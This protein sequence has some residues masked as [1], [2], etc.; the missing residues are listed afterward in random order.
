LKDHYG[1]M[2][3]FSTAEAP[4]GI[5]DAILSPAT[6][7]MQA[8]L[9]KQCMRE[10]VV[11]MLKRPF[12]INPVTRMWLS[13]DGNSFLRHSLSEYLKVVEIGIA[14]V[15]GSVQDERTFSTVSFLKNKVCNR[16]TTHGIVSEE[17][18]LQPPYH[19]LGSSGWHDNQELL[20][21]QFVPL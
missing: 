10:N 12:T 9:F 6:L 18:S 21:H 5:L 14:I 8:S 1:K 7:N 13:I 17:Q 11:C 4:E 15:L 20:R 16:L 19:P 3:P 2:V